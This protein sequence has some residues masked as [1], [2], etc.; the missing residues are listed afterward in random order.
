MVG[1]FKWMRTHVD[2]SICSFIFIPEFILYLSQNITSEF[3]AE[4]FNCFCFT[5]LSS[6]VTAF[7]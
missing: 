7:L 2:D 5:K 3:Y 4:F 6:L 1:F